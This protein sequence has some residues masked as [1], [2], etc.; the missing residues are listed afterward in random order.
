MPHHCLGRPDASEYAAYYRTYIGPVADG[1]VLAL[2]VAQASAFDSLRSLNESQAMQRYAPDK[3]SIKEVI[4]HVTDA[5]R[6][7]CY[8]MLR[9]ARGDQTPLASF[10]QQPYVDAAKF[11]RLPITSLID[12]FRATRAAT[13]SLTCELDD[14]AWRRMGTA[15]GFP[16]SARALAYIIAGH[17]THH[18]GLLRNR[19][20]VAV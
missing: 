13:L 2:L 1:D 14:D 3:W 6:V 16:V 9:I 11:D 8:R 20:D 10:D 5:E 4:G 18:I 19:Y 12:A 15:S 17:A 7:F